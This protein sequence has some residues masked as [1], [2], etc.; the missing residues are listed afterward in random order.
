MQYIVAFASPSMLFKFCI[1]FLRKIGKFSP[2]IPKK[3]W[4]LYKEFRIPSQSLNFKTLGL[5]DYRWTRN[6]VKKYSISYL[7]NHWNFSSHNINPL[8]T[9]MTRVK[10]RHFTASTD[11]LAQ[12]LSIYIY[13]HTH[14]YFIFFLLFSKQFNSDCKGF[15]QRNYPTPA[16]PEKKTQIVQPS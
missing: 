8:H 10:A 1:H 12:R 2:S 13:T 3:K 4:Y 16:K 11:N 14:I 6:M 15:T 9:L 7:V 5:H